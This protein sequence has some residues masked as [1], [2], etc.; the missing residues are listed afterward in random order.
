MT[1]EWETVGDQPWP[2]P[3]EQARDAGIFDPPRRVEGAVPPPPPK[4]EPGY[5]F[6]T[7]WFTAPEPKTWTPA[8]ILGAIG[9]YLLS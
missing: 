7:E 3:N 2:P 4:E 6:E 5:T 1:V 9:L 8:L